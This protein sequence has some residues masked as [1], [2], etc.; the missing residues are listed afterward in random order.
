METMTERMIA[1]PRNLTPSY[2]LLI[3]IRKLYF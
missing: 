2:N 3:R 1:T